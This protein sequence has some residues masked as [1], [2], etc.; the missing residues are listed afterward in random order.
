VG[1][2][3]QNSLVMLHG[4]GA[5][6]GFFYKNFEALSRVPNWKLYALDLLGMGRSSRPHFRINGKDKETKVREAENWF[7]D[8]LEEWRIKRGIDKMTLLGHSLGGY[9]AVCYA[10]KYPGHLNKLILASPVGIPEDPYAVNEEMPDPQE[11]TMQ[12]EFTQSQDE[13]AGKKNTMP[14]KQPPR[15]QLP[16]WVKT[17]WDANI[18][19]FSLVRLSGPLGPRLVSGWTSRRFSHLPPAEAQ[20]LHDYAY[21]LFRQRGSGEYALAYILAP[22]AF[23]RS[24]LIRRIQGVGRQYL[25]PHSKSEPDNASM[26]SGST[27]GTDRPRE[28]GVPV[29]FIYGDKDWMDKQGGWDSEDKMKAE[30]KKALSNASE[31]EKRMENGSARTLIVKNAGHH[32]YLDGWDEFN[33]LMEEEMKD[34]E[35]RQAKLAKAR[36][37]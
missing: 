20:A 35:R 25:E 1:E 37:G 15:R 9:M 4:Y 34:V 17:L 24:P 36:E 23:A 21:S 33:R 31:E 26:K 10:L 29:V 19:P 13:T 27:S 30:R 5:G 22:G 8:A 7:V 14:A 6:L 11:S 32:V 28:T 12:H 18:S 16:G 2:D 3:A